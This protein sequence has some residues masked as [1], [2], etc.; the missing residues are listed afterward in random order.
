MPLTRACLTQQALSSLR[1]DQ[2]NSAAVLQHQA[3]PAPFGT[4]K[5]VQEWGVTASTVHIK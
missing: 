3:G 5:W 4:S 1:F 2:S